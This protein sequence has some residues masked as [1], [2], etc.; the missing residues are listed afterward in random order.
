MEENST[1][2]KII[3]EDINKMFVRS[4]IQNIYF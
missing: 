4:I 3:Q 2:I 1:L